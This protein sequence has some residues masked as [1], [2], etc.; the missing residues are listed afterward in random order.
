M[1]RSPSRKEEF[2]Q[3]TANLAAEIL[4]SGPRRVAATDASE[5]GHCRDLSARHEIIICWKSG[6]ALTLGIGAMTDARW[7]RFYESMADVGIVP[8]GMDPKKGYS[9]EFVNKGIGA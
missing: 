6:D 4:S 7:Q 9:L 5:T 2:E 8:K 3:L 1:P